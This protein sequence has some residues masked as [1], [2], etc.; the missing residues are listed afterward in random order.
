MKIAEKKKESEKEILDE[1]RFVLELRVVVRVTARGRHHRLAVAL[2]AQRHHPVK[3]AAGK[4]DRQRTH[5]RQNRVHAEGD[6]HDRQ[7]EH[8]NQI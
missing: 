4:R 6:R 5:R 3:N 7:T 1:S 8:K 2:F